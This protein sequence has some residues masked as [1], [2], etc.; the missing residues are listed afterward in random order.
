[1]N[2][3]NETHVRSALKNFFFSIVCGMW[4]GL[5]LG[6]GLG[7]EK[8]LGWRLGWLCGLGYMHT[9]RN[10]NH[11]KD[12]LSI[13]KSHWTFWMVK[14]SQ[15]AW[16]LCHVNFDSF[17]HPSKDESVT[18]ILFS[19]Y[20]LVNEQRMKNMSCVFKNIG[21]YTDI[22]RSILFNGNLGILIWI[23]LKFI[24]QGSMNNYSLTMWH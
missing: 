19:S 23:Q 8:G 11:H 2:I 16:W 5:G 20:S 1:M 14:N 15:S 13:S 21:H 4:Q 24:P 10:Q 6:L 17:Q 9:L 7:L 3:E 12:C 18:V 22:F